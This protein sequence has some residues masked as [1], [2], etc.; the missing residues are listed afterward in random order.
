MKT[1][2]DKHPLITSLWRTL[3][4]LMLTLAC[5]S[6]WAQ[7]SAKDFDH[8]KTGFNLTGIHVSQR[9]ESCHLR[10]V[11]KGTPRDCSSCHT[12]GSPFAGPDNIVKPPQHFFTPL[13][14]DNC[15]NTATFSGARFNH[16][17]V[18]PNA[19]GTC[20]NGV[21][22][23]GKPANHIMTTAPCGTCHRTT[24]WFPATG[25]DHSQFTVATICGSCHNGVQATGKTANHMPTTV[26]CIACHNT[27]AFKPSTWNHTQMPVTNQCSTCHSGAFPPADGKPSNHIPYQVLTGVVIPNCDT[28]HKAGY[29]SWFPGKFHS[30][31]TVTSQC[32][33][34]HLTS[35][36][37]LTSKPN[38]VTH[39]SVTGFCEN[40]HRSTASWL[41]VQYTHSPAN[42]VGTGTCDTCH[43]GVNAL[44]KPAVHIP[45]GTG[46]CDSCHLGQVTF[47][48]PYSMNHTVVTAMTCTTCHNGAY[49]SFGPVG[50]Q[51]MT[52]ISNHIPLAQLLNGTALDCSAC[53]SSTTSFTTEKMNH[54]S[55]QG[56]GSGWCIGCHRTGT[57]YAGSMQKMSLTHNS[58]GK[59]DCSVSG[60]HR[61]LGNTGA[62]YTKWK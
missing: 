30:N 40:C 8:V 29:T 61:P 36:Y 17:G 2:A 43:N 41:S 23:T 45:T 53:H 7:M 34:C 11:F 20:H 50:A 38:T 1:N 47:T 48:S 5:T 54:N 16:M 21:T 32:A 13:P 60:C 49:T 26:N 56:N 22:S 62:A 6:L 9:C 14:C 37:G 25:M 31:V 55:S 46:K 57:N 24:A 15:H 33:N 59:T 27:I 3:F 4:A 12:M 19:C 35:M 28:C 44:G 58:G 51:A 10:G 52:S 18:A 42:A 39:A